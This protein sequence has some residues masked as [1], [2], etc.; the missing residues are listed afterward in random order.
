MSKILKVTNTSMKNAIGAIINPI[1]NFIKLEASSGIFLFVV[2]IV[3]M[4]IA[5]TQHLSDRYFTFI[6]TPVIFTIGT[7]SLNKTLLLLVNDGLMA[8]FFYLIGLEI[9]KELLV[10]ELSSPRKAA[11]SFFGALGGM[12]VPALIYIYF[13]LMNGDIKGWGVPMATDIAFALGIISLLGNRIG[14]S[15]KVFLLSLAV[16]DD[17]GAIVVIALFYTKEIA[18][19]YLGVATFLLLVLFLLNKSGVRKI[20]IGLFLGFFIWFCFLKSGIHATL[21]GVILAFLTPARSIHQSTGVENEEGELL[22]DEYIHNLHPWS[23]FIIM[24]IFAFFNAGVNIQGLNLAEAIF[25][26][27]TLGIIVALVLGKPLGVFLFTYASSRLKLSDLPEETTWFQILGVGCIAGIGFTMSL[28]IS[29]LA[30][31][32]SEIERNSKIGIVIGSL[33]SMV[34]GYV[35]LYMSSSKKKKEENG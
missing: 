27:V 4:I 24:P 9:K 17:L 21:A 16:V 32:S 18:T 33:I 34:L 11:F 8:I 13:N 10:G 29:S 35:L 15:I 23:A 2:A 7:Y 31:D 30:F 6:N 3:T 19:N 28:F 5:N 26:P 1:Q 20:A 12:M 25:H 14:S 22:L